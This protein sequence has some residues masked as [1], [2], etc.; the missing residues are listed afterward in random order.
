MKTG[1]SFYLG[2]GLAFICSYFVLLA[3]SGSGDVANDGFLLQIKDPAGIPVNSSI[4]AMI[5]AHDF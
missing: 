5:P 4:S 2:L 1:V 3:S